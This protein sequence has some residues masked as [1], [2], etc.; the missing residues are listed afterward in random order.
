MS[1]A[2]DDIVAWCRH[3]DAESGQS[4]QHANVCTN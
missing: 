2:I 4:A 1:V 3:G